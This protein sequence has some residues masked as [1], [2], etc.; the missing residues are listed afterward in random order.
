MSDHKGLR[1]NSGKLRYDLEPVY[2]REQLIKV[3]TKGAEKYAPRN[4]ENGMSWMS[5]VASLKRHLAAFEKSEDIDHETGLLHMAHVMCNAAFLVEYYKIYPQGDDRPH[6]YH[7]LK[8]GLDIDEVICDWLGAWCEMWNI[9]KPTS[10]FFDRDLKERFDEMEKKGT[11]NDFYLNLKPLLKPED[12]P[13]EPH[14]YITSRRVPSEITEKWLDLNGFPTKPVYTVQPNTTKV[15]VAKESGIDIYVDDRF[16]NFV[17]LNKAG[18]C[19]FLY[20]APH[21]KRYD[22]GYKRIYSLKELVNA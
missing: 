9:E 2:A 22:V 11:L 8:I 1:Y 18:I 15:D 20:D 12:I 10:W 19:T 6:R 16:E 5:V 7:N 4:W 3:L 21:N 14:C 13:F 17:E